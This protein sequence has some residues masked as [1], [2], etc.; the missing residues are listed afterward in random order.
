M[1]NFG[2][3][4]NVFNLGRSLRIFLGLM[5][6]LFKKFIFMKIR[7][8]IGVKDFF[9]FVKVFYIGNYNYFVIG[10]CLFIDFLKFIFFKL[11]LIYFFWLVRKIV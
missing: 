2:V 5:N 11:F 1:S 3:N 4:F 7:G 8:L 6:L 10:V 9:F